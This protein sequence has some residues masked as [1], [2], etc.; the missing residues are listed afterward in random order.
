MFFYRTRHLRPGEVEP[1]PIEKAL[2][3][4]VIKTSP[5]QET[6][7]GR[8]QD[9]MTDGDTDGEEKLLRSSP[10]SPHEPLSEVGLLNLQITECIS[11]R[12]RT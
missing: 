5:N 12:K 4:H 1:K 11:Y 7:S 9:E 2:P 6:E 3:S 10:P 8:S